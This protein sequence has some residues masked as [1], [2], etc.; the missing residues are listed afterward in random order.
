[1]NAP[2]LQRLENR[3]NRKL[4]EIHECDRKSREIE[5]QRERVRGEVCALED[6]IDEVKKEMPETPDDVGIGIDP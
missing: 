5:L 2:L 3:R 4:S 1:M 6:A